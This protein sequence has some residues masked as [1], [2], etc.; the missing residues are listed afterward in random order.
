V[1]FVRDLG[2][3]TTQALAYEWITR[4]VPRGSA[5][6]VERRTLAVPEQH[7]RVTYP[8]WL[9]D[10]TKPGAPGGD[11]RFLVASSEV[12]EM[13]LR[14]P[15]G[16]DRTRRY[17]ELF[18]RTTERARFVPDAARRGPTLRILEI[19]TGGE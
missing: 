1:R 6:A 2:R 10:V 3:P 18:S 8:R 12:Y 16:R 5:S 17:G 4:H 15:D 7:Y 9:T 13:A 19:G 11:A 14:Q